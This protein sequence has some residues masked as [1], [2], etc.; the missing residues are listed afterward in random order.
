MDREMRDEQGPGAKISC[1]SSKNDWINKEIYID[2][3]LYRILLAIW[4]P[5]PSSSDCV[6][7][8]DW[9]LSAVETLG[10]SYPGFGK[11]RGRQGESCGD[12]ADILR[13]K[14]D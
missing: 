6:G 14:Q 11:R 12:P 8:A 4:L 5:R 10:G 3:G 13:R 9:K 2:P 1:L 7:F